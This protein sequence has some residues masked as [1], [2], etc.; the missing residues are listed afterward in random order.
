MWKKAVVP[1]SRY[2]HGIFLEEVRKIMK[3]TSW[4]ADL[5]IKKCSYPFD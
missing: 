4:I 1:N 2:Y 3:S 5:Q